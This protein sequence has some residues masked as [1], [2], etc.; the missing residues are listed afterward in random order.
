[1]PKQ[2]SNTRNL[3]ATIDFCIS[4]DGWAKLA[5]F[6]QRGKLVR[7]LHDEPLSAGTYSMKWDGIDKNERAVQAG[8]YI[9][10][11]EAEG[12]DLRQTVELLDSG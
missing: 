6:T 1:M 2:L 7:H 8:P 3:N 11:L 12:M 9:A 5:I 10:R 4:R